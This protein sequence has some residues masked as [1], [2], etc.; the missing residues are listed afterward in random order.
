MITQYKPWSHSAL[1]AFETC[2]RR[3][4]LTRVTKDVTE[5]QHEASLWGNRVHH[6]LEHYA[7][8]KVKLPADLQKYAKYVDKIR[9]YD[10]KRVVEERMAIDSNFRKTTWNA[11]N[12]WCRGIIDIGIVGSKKAYLLDWKT[13]KRKPGSDQLMLFAALAF[14]HYPWVDT[15][16]CGFIWLK[17]HKFDKEIYTR[18]KISDIWNEFL[19]R[20]NRLE[21]AFTEDKWPPKPS[22]LCKNYCPVGK[23]NCEFW[24]I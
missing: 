24:G 20:I 19:P 7:N 9:S 14:I 11:K 15:I 17:E 21:L 3:Y 12:V 22:G 18:D 10:G 13:G 8:K 2:P 6:H 1:T 4:H 5:Q 16:I 23:S